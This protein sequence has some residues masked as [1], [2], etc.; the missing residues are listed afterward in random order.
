MQVKKENLYSLIIAGGSGIRLW[1][2]SRQNS[3]KQFANLLGNE[4]LIQST[5]KRVGSLFNEENVYIVLGEDQKFDIKRQIEGLFSGNKLNILKEPCGRNTAPAVLLGVLQILSLDKDAV[6]LVFPSDHYIGDEKKFA[7]RVNKACEIA[8]E[9]PIVT[10]GVKPDRPETGYGYIERG[11]IFRED[12]FSIKRFTEKPD[13]KTAVEY[14]ESGNFYW[15]SGM[16]AFRASV[17]A[18][19]YKELAPEIYNKV[20]GSLGPAGIINARD[21]K[22]IPGI[23]FDYAI[24]E[25][26][27]KGVVLPADFQ[28]N[29]IGSWQAL[30]G[31]LPKDASG[32]A[33]SGDVYMNESRN[34]LIS[35]S[36]RLL[37]ANSLRN[38]CIVDTTDALFVSALDKTQ[39]VKDIVEEL[40]SQN[41]PEVLTHKKVLKPW[42]YYLD[43]ESGEGFHVKKINVLP[44]KRLSLQKHRYRSE[45]WVVVR[46]TATVRNGE[47]IYEL[48]PTQSTFIAMGNI[49]RLE[50][51][52]D[53]PLEIIE[54][55]FGTTLSEDDIVRIE[56][57]FG[58]N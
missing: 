58:R 17:I 13:L 37:V 12:S 54:V 24:M 31:L 22:N 16:F 7:E 45:N 48:T 19:E 6:I 52:T 5:L 18:D 11:Q 44:R 38:V 23:S 53:K 42:G 26:T 21:Y 49:H 47:K 39:E 8:L 36:D 28:W 40:K 32:N 34:C 29:D 50:N 57:D 35:G 55:Q 20:C 2:L 9:G 14:I 56:D 1:P 46:G 41:R 25:K 3:P 33:V 15:N 43:M 30:H 51:R 4:S 27:R 10:F